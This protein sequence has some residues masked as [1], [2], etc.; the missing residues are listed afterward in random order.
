MKPLRHAFTLVE[1]VAVIVIFGI[2]AAI[3][4]EIY[5]KIYENYMVSRVMNNLQ[6][7]TELA[8][9][10][11]ARRLQ[12]RIK[13]A[14]IARKPPPNQHIIISTADP[15]LD[16]SYKILEWIGYDNEGL[17]GY[18]NGSMYTPA[19]SA[20]IDVDDSNS[21][22]LSTPGSNLDNEDAIIKAVS[23]NTSDINNSG[24]ILTGASGA[25]DIAEYGWDPS[26]S[27]NNVYDIAEFNSTMF[28]V[29]DAQK[30]QEVYER[31]KLVWSAFAIAPDPLT[32]NDDCNL[33]FYENYQP[34]KGEAFF[35]NNI[36][37]MKFLLLEHVTTFK[38]KQDGDII[39]LKLCVRDKIVNNDVSI[40]KEKVVF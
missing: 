40:C 3:G 10:Q 31:Y 17:K 20:F 33:S 16:D 32:C 14:T 28:L 12:Y 35:D 4:S 2:V 29:T 27:S 15:S 8:L 6:T 23:Y 21:T 18:F 34:W 19:W 24:V 37:V 36:G 30:P 9:E 1:L 38:F 25:F 39:R 13:S 26:A 7:K 22:Y 5:V 11:I